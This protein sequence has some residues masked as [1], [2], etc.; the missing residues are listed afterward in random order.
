[1]TDRMADKEERQREARAAGSRDTRRFDLTLNGRTYQRL[2]KRRLAYEVLRAV[3]LDCE[4]PPETVLAGTTDGRRRGGRMLVR[5]DGDLD[6][7]A[8]KRAL[9]ESGRDEKRFYTKEADLLRVGGSTW[10][11]TTGWGETTEL[12]IEELTALA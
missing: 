3:V 12:F 5:F 4:V 7:V 6:E 11:F 9:A 2:P 1:L 10:V 8:I